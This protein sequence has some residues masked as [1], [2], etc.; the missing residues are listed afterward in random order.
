VSL[1]HD[2]LSELSTAVCSVVGRQARSDEIEKFIK[3]NSLLSYWNR[4]HHLTSLRTPREVVRGLFIDSLL[5]LSMIPKRR[6]LNVLDIGSGI[7]IPG[8]PIRIVDPEIR[9]TLI[10]ANRKK[11]SFLTAL[12]KEIGIEEI[13]IISG[14]AE[15][16][17]DQIPELQG[18]F[19]CVVIRAAGSLVRLLPV[20]KSYLN[21]GGIF[22]ASG[23]PIDRT[24]S[25]PPPGAEWRAVSNPSL[26]LSR[27]FLFVRKES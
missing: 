22:V 25:T 19:D 23:P 18:S 5:F 12:K 21:P 26:G 15:S 14:R 1:P 27:R 13:R 6:P 2:L 11:V 24:P 10:E 8:I 7:G 3:F 16:I 20:A 4:V 17:V 9:L